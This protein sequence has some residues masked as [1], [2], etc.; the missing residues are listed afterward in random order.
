MKI[1][2]L[3]IDGVLNSAAWF[4]RRK[5]KELDKD[6]F[7]FDPEAVK[8]LNKITDETGAKIVLSSTWRKNR[9]LESLRELF[10]NVGITGELI[11]KTPVLY[12]KGPNGGQRSVPRGVEIKEW[13]EQSDLKPHLFRSYVIIDDDSDM[14]YN[15][16]DNFFNTDWDFGLGPSMRYRIIN[17]LKGFDDGDKT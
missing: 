2:F 12:F 8:E 15:Q 13:L 3:D 17:F 9:S 16:R 1:I 11:D 6:N 7:H 14:L 5:G 10:Q 4:K